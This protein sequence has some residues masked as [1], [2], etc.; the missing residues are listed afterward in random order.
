[1]AAYRP[2]NAPPPPSSPPRPDAPPG[3]LAPPVAPVAVSFVQRLEQLRN[4]EKKLSQAVD[5]KLKEMG[6]VCLRSETNTCGR[7]LQRAPDPWLAADGSQCSGYE[8]REALEG[9]FCGHWG[10]P[11]TMTATI[12]LCLGT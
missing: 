11:V 3:L 1:M 6:G 4:E 10:S 7:T 9:S 5:A 8:T 12:K 2:P